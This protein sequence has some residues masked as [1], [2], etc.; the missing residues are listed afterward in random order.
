VLGTER[1]KIQIKMGLEKNKKQGTCM[2]REQ[3][4]PQA[5]LYS[6]LQVAIKIA[7]A[8]TFAF[9][10]CEFAIRLQ[11]SKNENRRLLFQWYSLL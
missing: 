7:F 11:L 1:E 10:D 5:T 9:D 6:A 8:V 3:N 2:P 4:T